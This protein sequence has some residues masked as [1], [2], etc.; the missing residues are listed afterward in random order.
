MSTITE[1]LRKLGFKVLSDEEYEEYCKIDP[2]YTYEDECKNED[3][4]VDE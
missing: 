4:L 3:D 2:Q 1:Y